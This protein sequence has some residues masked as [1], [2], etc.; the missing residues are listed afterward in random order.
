M[1]LDMRLEKRNYVKNWSHMAPEEVHEITVKKGGEP[2]PDIKPSRIS[3]ITE[4]VAYWRKAN[5]IHKWF[6]DNVQ[7]GVDDCKDYYVDS[8]Q[9]EELRDVCKQVLDASKLVEGKIKNGYSFEDGKKTPIMED[10]KYI[11]DATV[12]HKLLPTAEGFFFGSTD[13]DEYYL[14]D[15]K[16]T[17]ETLDALL[18]EGGYCD[19]Y[20][21]SSW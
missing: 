9:L 8:S 20:Y 21:N 5:H 12:A 18:K 6:V 3:Y 16:F 11:E 2:R 13:Y 15:I 1:G 4:E 17:Y 14:Q 10:G 19:Y 7:D